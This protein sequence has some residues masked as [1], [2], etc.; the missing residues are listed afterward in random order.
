IIGL[1]GW[2]MMA[3][4]YWPTLRLYGGSLLLALALPA[5]A[6][7]YTLMTLDSARRHW[8]GQGGAWKGRVYSDAR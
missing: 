4:A 6:L 1:A 3:V 5:I 2:L 7:M 8:M